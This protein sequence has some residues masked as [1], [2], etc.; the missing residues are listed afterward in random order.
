MQP[1]FKTAIIITI[2]VM[3]VGIYDEWDYLESKKYI[4]LYVLNIP[5]V[6]LHL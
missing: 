2:D 5:N 4:Y 6:T 3:Q 1:M